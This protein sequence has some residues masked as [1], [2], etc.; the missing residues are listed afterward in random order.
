M[1]VQGL[2]ASQDQTHT[3]AGLWGPSLHISN[4]SCPQGRK[5]EV[6]NPAIR[7]LGNVLNAASEC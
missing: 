7:F 6:H 1:L 4:Q 5:A 3:L 2:R